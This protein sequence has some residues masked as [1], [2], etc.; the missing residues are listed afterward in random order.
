MIPP[1]LRAEILRLAHA[2]KWP[3]GT[4]ARHLRLHHSVVR[5]VLERDGAPRPA[6]VRSSKVDPFVPF[7]VATLHKY[8]RLSA[9]RLFQMVRERGYD[10]R[11]DHFRTLVARYRPA[12]PAEAYLRL[13]TL[14]GEQ[15]QVDWGHFGH[16]QIGRAR[17]PLIA[18]VVVLAYSRAIFVRF[19]PGLHLAF[20]LAGHQLAFRALQGVPRTCLYDNLKS[21]VLDREGDAIRFNPQILAFAGHYRFEPR[22][23][24]PYRGN[25]KG[26]VERA[27]RYLRDNF[28]PARS[29]DSF[30]DANRQAAEWCATVALERRWPED[31]DLTVADAL[32]RDRAALRPLPETDFPCDQRL[33]L[34][35]GKT[36]YLR[37]DLNDYSVPHTHTRK[38]VVLF[39]DLDRVRIFDGN[40]VI[41]SHPRSFDRDQQIED[42]RHLAELESAKRHARKARRSDLLARLVPSS[43]T[44]LE[45]LAAQHIALGRPVAELR[46]LLRSYGAARLEAAIVEALRHGAAH[47]AAVR[48][49]LERNRD[50]AGA[51]PALPLSLPDDP[52]LAQ[53]DFTPHSLD[54]YDSFS[55][56][57]EDR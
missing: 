57:K 11:P 45:R 23:V 50:A 8:P 27:I 38:L 22:P 37:F 26:R 13:R 39:A 2:E 21:V 55:N 49:I 12:R 32:V 56:P 25:E 36:P 16:I 3:P 42:P 51:P 33:E 9:A 19:F 30:D 41:A 48:H 1:A 18:F 28:L 5:R 35:S 43:A 54:Q 29:F 20:F 31:R 24:A 52:R 47:P 53:L 40:D 17:R 10:G 6:I 15:A 46:V 4:I 7:I 44:L 14:P 34:R